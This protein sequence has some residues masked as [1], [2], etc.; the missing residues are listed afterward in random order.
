MTITVDCRAVA[1]NCARST[2]RFVARWAGHLATVTLIGEAW[3]IATGIEIARVTD[4]TPYHDGRLRMLE[5]RT[6]YNLRE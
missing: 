2:D 1:F 6:G 4:L 5:E 3:P